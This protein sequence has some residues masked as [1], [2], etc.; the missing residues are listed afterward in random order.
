VIPD[1]PQRGEKYRLWK[2][3]VSSEPYC[4]KHETK[5]KLALQIALREIAE[6]SRVEIYPFHYC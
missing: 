3:G 1:Y 4:P 6:I 5:P 2:G